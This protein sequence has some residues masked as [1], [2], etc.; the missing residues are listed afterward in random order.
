ME[1]VLPCALCASKWVVIPSHQAYLFGCRLR[2]EKE[3][4]KNENSVFDA[5]LSS[6]FVFWIF[7]ARAHI[8]VYSIFISANWKLRWPAI[9]QEQDTFMPNANF[10]KCHC[11]VRANG[12]LNTISSDKV[13]HTKFNSSQRKRGSENYMWSSSISSEVEFTTRTT[14]AKPVW[15][16]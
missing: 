11:V 7:F 15:M 1:I 5:F 2:T 14:L 9:P 12:K 3:M 8:N 6:R 4:E 16:F 13:F 10:L